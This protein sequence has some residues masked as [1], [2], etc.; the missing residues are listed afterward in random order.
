MLRAIKRSYARLPD[1]TIPPTR[2]PPRG[3]LRA[4]WGALILFTLVLV[5]AS[6]NPFI[7]WRAPEAFT[8][9][10]WPKYWSVFDIVLNVLAYIP[11][12]ALLAWQHGRHAPIAGGTL[13][14]SAL[15]AIAIG[16]L[17]S[18][19]LELTQ[20]MLPGRVCSLFDV[21]ANALGSAM[22]ALAVVMTP[23]RAAL[24][25]VARW[26]HRHF[27]FGARAEWGILLLGL[28]LFAQLNP[29]IPFFQA[30][31][32]SYDIL[33]AE[34]P[35]PY[36][37]LFL[38]PQALGVA[39]NVCGFA[40]FVA[41]ILHPAKRKL[42]NALLI[43]ALGFVAKV[44]AAALMLKAPL[45]VDWISPATLIGLAFGVVMFSLAVR[46]PYRW[47]VFAATLLVF[48]GGLMAKITSI[49]GALDETLRLFNWPYGHLLNFTS[50]TRWAHEVWPLL[51]CLFLA[52]VFLRHRDIP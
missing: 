46:L 50:L 48:A 22:G 36:D 30:G 28:W 25:Q 17:M 29:A 9:L 16:L 44:S 14:R 27:A 43:L 37:P 42:I 1:F 6:L 26:R 39:L 21:L 38:L 32:L 15:F 41:V 31:Y 19:A 12:G 3:S 5:Y 45:L 13:F 18:V 8:L 11:F 49:Y 51:A 47:R 4:G 35:H 20:L 40:M 2:T 52:I 23:G 24:A 10:S 7:G 34:K 33:T